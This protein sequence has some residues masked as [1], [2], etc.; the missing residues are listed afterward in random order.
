[1][2]CCSW[3]AALSDR[4]HP[5]S[6]RADVHRAGRD[7]GGDARSRQHACCWPPSRFVVGVGDRA[8][9]TSRCPGRRMRRSHL[10]P[11]YQGGIWASLVIGIGF[12]SIYA[13]RIASE[14]ARMQAGLAATQLAL[15]RE[16]RLASLGALA[17]AAA[18]ELGTPLGTIAVVARELERA[19]PPNSPEAEDVRLLR[20]GSRTLPRHPHAPR[21]SR[22]K[23]AE[24][25]GPPA[26][27][28]LAR[29]HRQPISRRRS[30][31][32][33]RSRLKTSRAAARAESLARRR[34]CC[35]GSAMS[36][37]M[38]PISRAPACA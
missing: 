6:V 2:T 30:D 16:H 10:P 4:R 11:L 37:P 12:T 29:R 35:M 34:S 26:A 17:T 23:R 24:R 1:M 36:S 13:W 5:K 20:S 32:A 38:R 3:R 18:H 8:S 33:D 28:R 19:L 9:I 15:A 27:R 22:R 7:R 25:A 21:A 14:G 31:G